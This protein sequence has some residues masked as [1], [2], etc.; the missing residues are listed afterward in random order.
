MRSLKPKLIILIAVG[1]LVIGAAVVVVLMLVGRPK[2]AAANTIDPP[3][4]YEIGGI[5]ITALPVPEEGVSVYLEEP[6]S[7]PDGEEG[8]D[9]PS[10][11]PQG[12]ESGES[13]P[14]VW[15]EDGA[16]IYRYE[17]WPDSATTVSDYVELLTAEE[18]GFSV[19]DESLLRTDAP[20]FSGE[21]GILRIARGLQDGVVAYLELSWA[22]DT[23]T[24]LAGAREGEVADPPEPEGMTLLEMV[25][26]VSSRPPSALGPEGS[27]ME[28]Y[29]IYSS[30]GTV[31]VNGVPCVRLSICRIAENT[32]TNQAVGEYFLSGDRKHIYRLNVDTGMVEEMGA[33]PAG[34]N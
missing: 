30:S 11:S 25:D 32:D 4:E 31:M 7:A 20:D 16:V 14:P 28:E 2:A 6:E 13:A 17:G 34:S 26:Y 19:V 5:P 10:E 23:C 1:V 12:E 3:A 24:V 22:S 9:A 33:A 29:N 8:E 21:E 15:T 18:R 27:S